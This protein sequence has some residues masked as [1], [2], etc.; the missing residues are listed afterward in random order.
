MPSGDKIAAIYENYDD[1]WHATFKLQAEKL[2]SWLGTNKGYEYSRDDGIMP[3]VERVAQQKCGVSTKDSWNPADIYIV[4]KT[5]RREIE[6]EITKIGDMPGTAPQRLDMLN[7]YM[8]KQFK[9]RDLVGISLKKLGRT[10]TVEET[11]IN[12]QQTLKEIKIIPN[13]MKL[14]LDLAANG[15]FVTGE[16]KFQIEAEGNVVNVQVRAFSGG[17]R[18]KTQM[19]MTA[20]GAAAKLGKVSV[21]EAI[22]PFLNSMSPQQKLRSGTDLPK[23]GAFTD[24]DIKKY[25]DEQNALKRVTI[26]GS[27]PIDFG[28]NDFKTTLMEAI[29]LEQDNNRTASQLSAK[30]QCFEWVRILKAAEQ[31]GKLK[32]FLSVLY[33]GAK[34]QYA[35]AGPF[36]KIS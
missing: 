21:I 31:Q 17:I 18:E 4:R 10:A 29:Q 19:D 15:E 7:E 24:A 23:V 33:Y 6:A 16:F 22:N 30:L 32:D 36:L 27:G 35:T 13:S 9:S 25:V 1:D 3:F 2:K 11:N 26:G 5:K 20:A 12:R 34:K 8:R 14:D 28:R